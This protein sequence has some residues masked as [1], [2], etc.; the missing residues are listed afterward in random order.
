MIRTQSLDEGA[1]VL[2]TV[3]V[4]IKSYP[5]CHLFRMAYSYPFQQT[6][7]HNNIRRMYHDF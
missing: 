3:P 4:P 7:M 1:V 6:A 5:T 2:P